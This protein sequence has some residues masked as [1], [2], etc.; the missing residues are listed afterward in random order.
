MSVRR[1]IWPR[2]DA[3]YGITGWVRL[4]L[5]W[6]PVGSWFIRGSGLDR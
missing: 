3:E 5:A 1:F 4:F 6:N 2:Y